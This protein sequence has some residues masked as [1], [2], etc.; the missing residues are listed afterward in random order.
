MIQFGA[1]RLFSYMTH[2]A[3]GNAIAVPQA[4][5]FGVL[6][7]VDLDI[8]FEEKMLYGAKQFPVAVAR[9]KGKIEGKSKIGSFNGRILG[10]YVFGSS[11]AAG[12]RGLVADYAAT[13]PTTPFQVTVAP[14]N[15]GAIA[16]DLGVRNAT[17]G[18]A[19][20]RVAS[21]PSTGE[22]SVS[23]AVYTFASADAGNAV[24]ISYDYTASSTTAKVGTISNLLMGYT[25][26]FGVRLQREYKG[27]KMY[28]SLVSCS[29]S[30]FSLPAQNDDF[31]IADFNFAA[32]SNDAD[33]VGYWSTSE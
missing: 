24:L 6:Q 22:Y 2:D 26:F 5:Q 31:V 13:V 3:Q 28:L 9:G 14:P 25:P 10:D 27:K 8:S 18:L 23:G 33:V 29:S 20:T 4:V 17:T 1:G 19:L 16:T 7:N 15:S 32:L 21:S 11:G 30:S 12:E